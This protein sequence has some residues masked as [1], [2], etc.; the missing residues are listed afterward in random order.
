MDRRRPAP[1]LLAG[2]GALQFPSVIPLAVPR[3]LGFPL[4]FFC[5]ASNLFTASNK[6]FVC[7]VCENGSAKVCHGRLCL[8]SGGNSPA[9]S[10]ER[11]D[12]RLI[13]RR[14]QVSLARSL[15]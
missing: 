7:A 1:A 14:G 13:R 8:E 12:L 11:F 10:S 4:Y 15:C 5:A 9:P 2:G 3:S 6:A